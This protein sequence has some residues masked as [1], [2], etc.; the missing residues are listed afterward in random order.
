[1]ISGVGCLITILTIAAVASGARAEGGGPAGGA[2]EVAGGR[3]RVV[4]VAGVGRGRSGT[5]EYHAGARLLEGILRRRADLAPIV[6]RD[7]W[8]GSARVF[9]GASTL[10]F[11]S[12][13]G[14]EHPFMRPER[15]AAI[16]KHVDGGGGLVLL[17]GA[18]ELPDPQGQQL[19]DWLGG[20]FQPG[21]SLAPRPGWLA[22]FSGLADH[23]T[24]RG[25]A[26]FTLEDEWFLRLV[27]PARPGLTVVLRANPS[28]RRLVANA[29]VWT[30][31]REVPPG[32]VPVDLA[33]NALVENLDRRPPPPPSAEQVREERAEK[34]KGRSGPRR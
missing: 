17:H 32:G 29:I 28:F 4:L 22:A 12:D 26:P 13:G 21:A 25:V 19:T 16:G 24:A 30:A 9:A 8:P 31:G 6:V 27:V 34:M 5:H 33:T 7:G 10:V 3:A 2:R 14:R 11:F 23:P 1:M 20:R 15:M 18:L